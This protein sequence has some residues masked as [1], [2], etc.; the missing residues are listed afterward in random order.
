MDIAS[1]VNLG[2]Q[3]LSGLISGN[4]TGAASKDKSLGAVGNSIAG[5][6]GGGLGGLILSL[7]GGEGLSGLQH[8]DWQSILAS[9]VS[10]GVGGGVL[11]P[12][13]GAIKKAMGK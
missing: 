2:I 8:L 12:I 3:L 6:A 10:G 1:I 13:I 11:T 5:L 9:I 7:L 4:V